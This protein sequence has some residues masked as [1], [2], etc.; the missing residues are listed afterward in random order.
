MAVVKVD[1]RLYSTSI[2]YTSS[3]SS[4]ARKDPPSEGG[5]SKVRVPL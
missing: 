4:S 5:H 2:E 3:E 1:N